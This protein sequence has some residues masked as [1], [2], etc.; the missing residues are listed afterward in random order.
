MVVVA[1]SVTD[2]VLGIR[3]LD[4][5]VEH[6]PTVTRAWVGA[7]FQHDVAIHGACLGIDVEVVK[8]SDITPGFVPVKRRRV[9][10]QTNG[11]MMPHRRLR[12]P[13]VREP[14]GVVG[15]RHALG[16]NREPG[17]AV[18]RHQHTVPAGPGVN[19]ATNPGL[20]TIRNLDLITTRQAAA[21][22]AADDL[23]QQIAKLASELAAA[24]SELTDLAITR[25]TPMQLAHGECVVPARPV[26]RSGAVVGGA[27][28]CVSPCRRIAWGR[29]PR[30]S[31]SG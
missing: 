1:A 18:D 3:L 13:R 15:V 14:A 16:V 20:I 23:R 26:A 2:N 21:N 29:H 28:G 7:G 17:P 24:E 9:V 25:R 10:E 6:T 12:N 22:A 31:R 4:Q 27:A 8:R 11:T 30:P 19:T 5:V